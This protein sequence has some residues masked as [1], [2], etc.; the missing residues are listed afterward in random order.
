VT[1]ESTI[2]TEAL[3]ALRRTTGVT[4]RL[5]EEGAV[6][7]PGD[8]LV[9]IAHN[10]REYLYLAEVQAVHRFETPGQLKH[11]W[12]HRAVEHET[13]LVARYIT[14]EVAARCRELKLQFIDTAGN[15]YLE[16]EGLFVYVVGQHRSPH[17]APARF[18][19]QTRAG[20]QVTF[21]LLCQPELLRQ[22]YRTIAASADVALG[23][24]AQ[25]MRDLEARRFLDARNAPRFL[26][27]RR[28]LH[29]WVSHYPKLRAKLNARRFDATGLDTS[30]NLARYNAYWGGEVAA[31]KLT[32]FLK[33]SHITIY[34]RPP[35]APL[36]AATRMKADANGGIEVLDVF[37]NELR[38]ETVA[39]IVPAV[40]V[41]A[42]LAVS[43][44]SRNIEAARLV[45]ER[46][47]E[48]RF[49]PRQATG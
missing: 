1:D 36:V 46:H 10:G 38:A 21:A 14:R 19:A 20:L 37:W 6:T 47:I 32:G 40:L 5:I 25:V 28:L 29:E 3:E 13:L 27:P 8:P 12:P 9:E 26:D 48:P 16:R 41:Y 34:A 7:P 39:D 23:T 35:I 31:D 30:A 49:H 42:D 4:A 17:A 33:P 18:R 24:V 44:D 11:R 22:N 2:C 45:Y 15:A 43:N